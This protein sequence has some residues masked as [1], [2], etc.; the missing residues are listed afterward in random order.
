MRRTL[1]SSAFGNELKEKIE[2][3]KKGSIQ[4]MLDIDLLDEYIDS[5]GT[6]N[7]YLVGEITDEN[8][9]NLLQGIKENGFRGNVDVWKMP[10]GRYMIFSGHRRTYAL[11]KL[12]N[13]T[14]P[15]SVYN[16]P[17]SEV[18]CRMWYLRANIHARGSA[19]AAIE[20]GHIYISRQM[21]YLGNIIRMNGFEGSERELNEMIAKEYGTSRATVMYYRAMKNMSSRLLELEAKGLVPLAQAATLCSMDEKSQDIIMDGIESADSNNKPLTRDELKEIISEVKDMSAG[22]NTASDA[23]E[24]V[25]E[26]VNTYINASKDNQ[27]SEKQEN[28]IA[29]KGKKEATNLIKKLHAFEKIIDNVQPD[30][31]IELKTEIGNF[32]MQIDKHQRDLESKI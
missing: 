14:I 8:T 12:G 29:P 7:T 13:V 32:L 6:T 24:N 5:E 4:E 28:V 25:K 16:K 11:R 31:L 22:K 9:A 26:I 17:E 20:G 2:K 27:N 18:E 15:C 1:N 10:N 21:E 19:H 23:T 3:N 30:T